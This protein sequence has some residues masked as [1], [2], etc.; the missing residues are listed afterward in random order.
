MAFAYVVASRRLA[1]AAARRR[2]VV[3]TTT[4]GAV[5][6][7]ARRCV[8]ARA[9][10]SSSSTWPPSGVSGELATFAGGCFW[11]TEL[12][13]QRVLGVSATAV[14]YTSGHTENPTYE[15]V[16]SGQSG[17]SEGIQMVFDP[18][19]VSYAE[20]VD[21]H[22]ATHDPTTLN[23]QGFDVGTQYR[24]GIYC[25][26][27]EQKRIAQ[28]RIDEWNKMNGNVLKKV[29]TEVVEASTFWPAEKYHQQYLSRGGRFGMAQSAEKGCTDKVRCYG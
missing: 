10:A 14:G 29:V 26:N 6:A 27:E 11:G 23:R 19:V 20:L 12:H 25:H 5:T 15:Q 18:A 1:S 17:H 22:L 24:S 2:A 13:F 4:S 3:G 7:H 9:A 28:E 21:K 8:S 16:C